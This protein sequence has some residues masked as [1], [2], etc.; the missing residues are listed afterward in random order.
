MPISRCN[1]AGFRMMLGLAILM[2]SY[3]TLTPK[4]YS[5]LEFDHADK[6]LHAATFLGLAFLADAG[7]PERGFVAHKYLPLFAYGIAI[8]CLQH[9]IPNRFFSLLDI[10]AN[11]SGLVIYGLLLLPLLLR[12]KIR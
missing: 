4:D 11:T 10:A 3:L 6:L 7:W 8:E 9:F 12:W 2:V 5:P 1:S